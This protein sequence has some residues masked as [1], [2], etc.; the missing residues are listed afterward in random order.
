VEGN[1]A[2]FKYEDIYRWRYEAVP[3]LQQGLGRYFG[4]YNEERLHQALDYR[5]PGVVYRV[6]G[7]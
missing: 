5:T 1:D 2:S 3:A 4:F 7:R 6:G